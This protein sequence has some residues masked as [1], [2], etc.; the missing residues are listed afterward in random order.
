MKEIKLT[1]VMDEGCLY[2]T[3]NSTKWQ[4]SFDMELLFPELSVLRSVKSFDELG[5]AFKM[6]VLELKIKVT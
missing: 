6:Q 2:S 4:M 1:E 5:P 3:K